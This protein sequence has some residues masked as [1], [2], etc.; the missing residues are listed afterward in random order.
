MNCQLLLNI[1]FYQV[2]VVFISSN[3][4][5]SILLTNRFLTTFF[6]RYG[7]KNLQ[8]CH[9]LFLLKTWLK[10]KKCNLDYIQQHLQD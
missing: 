8:A 6:T 10:H 3:S 9:R 7:T 2:F 5:T 4:I 1:N